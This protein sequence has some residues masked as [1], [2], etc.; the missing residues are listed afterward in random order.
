MVCDASPAAVLLSTLSPS[1]VS[2]LE[3]MTYWKFFNQVTGL[4]G[5]LDAAGKLNAPHPWYN[6]FLPEQEIASHLMGALDNPYLT[7]SEPIIIYPMNSTR[8][9]RPFFIKPD[10]PVFYL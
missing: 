9:T 7:G 4:V 3:E 8:F 1:R 10:S 5:A 6:V 2:P